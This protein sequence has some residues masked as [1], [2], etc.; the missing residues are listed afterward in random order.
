MRLVSAARS[1]NRLVTVQKIFKFPVLSDLTQEWTPV[2]E[3]GEHEQAW[4]PFSLFGVSNTSGFLT[5]YISK[6]FQIN[7]HDIVDV[8]PATKHQSWEIKHS[9]PCIVFEFENGIV[10]DRL[11]KSW[12]QVVKK[13]EILRTVFIPHD[14]GHLQV[15]SIKVACGTEIYSVDA[16]CQ[17]LIEKNFK[18]IPPAPGT[19]P[20]HIMVV[21]TRDHT[22]FSLRISHA[23]YDGWCIGEYWKD[24]GTAFAGSTITERDQFR[25]CLYAT[26]NADQS[27]SYDYW[28]NLLADESLHAFQKF[29][30]M[31]L[32]ARRSE[33]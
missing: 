12:D 8:L 22:T 31:V 14:G 2:T 5:D 32:F 7:I 13:H 28:R 30:A 18:A 3:D 4:S 17:T 16:M 21:K 19:S 6:R 11:L 10:V 20:L 9:S 25:K 15:F 29:A 26:A 23:L 27:G 33:E 1:K 24:W